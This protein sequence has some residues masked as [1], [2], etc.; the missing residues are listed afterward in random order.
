MNSLDEAL[1]QLPLVAILRGLQPGNAIDVG[2][3]LVDAGFRVIRS[4]AELAAA[5]HEHRTS[6]DGTR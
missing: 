3:L 5:A 4:A 2:N 1:D 6:G